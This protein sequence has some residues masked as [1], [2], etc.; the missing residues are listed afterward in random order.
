MWTAIAFIVAIVFISDVIKQRYKFKKHQANLP[1]S[2]PADLKKI[3]ELERRIQSLET[4]VIE[5]EKTERYR[6]L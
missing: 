6:N 5:L 3:E 2:N 4:I 1:E